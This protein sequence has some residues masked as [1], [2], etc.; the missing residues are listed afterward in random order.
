MADVILSTPSLSVLGGPSSV[1]VQLESG[2]TGRRGSSVFFSNGD[3]NVPGALT[4]PVQVLDLAI[5]VLASDPGYRYLYQYQSIDG[6]FSWA[7]QIS[8]SPG[9]ASFNAFVDFDAAGKGS[10]S[11]PLASLLGSYGSDSVLAEDFVI[12]ATMRRENTTVALSIG[13]PQIVVDEDDIQNL[14][15]DIYA[16]YLDVNAE[17]IS[18]LTG[19]NNVYLSVSIGSRLNDPVDL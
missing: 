12:Q 17:S 3:P 2:A 4:Q 7:K 5:N 9:I 8:L 16:V 10:V 15:F 18:Y 11:I 14:S 13:L 6:S 1:N 19:A